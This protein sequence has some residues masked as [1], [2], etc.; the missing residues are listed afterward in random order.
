MSLLTGSKPAWVTDSPG[1]TAVQPLEPL[2]MITRQH[3]A[4]G[5]PPYWPLRLVCGINTDGGMFTPTPGVLKKTRLE[6]IFN[7]ELTS[8]P[9]SLFDMNGFPRETNKH[10]LAEFLWSGDNVPATPPR[11]QSHENVKQ[12]LDGGSLLHRLP[13]RGSSY[14]ELIEMYVTFVSRKYTDATI[15]FDGYCSGPGTKDM[16][17]LH[18]N[19]GMVGRSVTFTFT[20]DIVLCEKKEVFLSNP[21]NKQQFLH[22]LSSAFEA[23]GFVTFLRTGR[24]MQTTPSNSSGISRRCPPAAFKVLPPTSSAARYHSYRV[25]FQVQEWANLAEKGELLPENW[26]WELRE[27]QLL[28]VT[29]DLPPAP[30][31]LLNIINCSCK[32]DCS[33]GKCSCRKHGLAC[34]TA[35]GE[36]HGI[37]CT[38][39]VQFEDSEM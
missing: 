29:M 31:V 18:R 2:R 35:C 39:S 24:E 20:D 38:N 22:L 15:I 9:T 4:H 30:E 23:R 26:G 19:K 5:F 1:S 17:H 34:T 11:A 33:S 25:Y 12:I 7:H 36:C 13:P 21:H 37:S 16:T 6:D 32:K 8:L 27:N 28:P 14:R 10:T 3:A